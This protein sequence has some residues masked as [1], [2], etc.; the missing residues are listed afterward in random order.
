MPLFHRAA[1]RNRIAFKLG[2]QLALYRCEKVVHIAVENI[3]EH[4]ITPNYRLDKIRNLWYHKHAVKFLIKII[5][6]FFAFVKRKMQC[7]CM[8]F[9]FYGG[10]DYD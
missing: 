6:R 1:H 4:I 7:I 3:T 8:F 2:V 9:E 5:R 10:Y